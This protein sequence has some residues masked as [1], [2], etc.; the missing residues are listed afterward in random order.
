MAC[1]VVR[2][3]VLQPVLVVVVGVGVVSFGVVMGGVVELVVGDDPVA[4]ETEGADVAVQ[5][6]S[7]PHVAMVRQHSLSQQLSPAGQAPPAQQ[8][9]AAGS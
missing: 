4:L 2:V 8:I 6:P 1:A 3:G 5:K 7:A 9:S